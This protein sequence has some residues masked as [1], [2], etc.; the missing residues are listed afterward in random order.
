MWKI[1]YLHTSNDINVQFVSRPRL[2]NLAIIPSACKSSTTANHSL[3]D[4]SFAV[5]GPKLWNAMPY[6]LNSISEQE[7][8]KSQLTKFMLS[9]PDTPPIRGYTPQNSNLTKL[10]IGDIGR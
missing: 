10:N 7:L 3:Y 9:L 8:F 4:S 5:I 1:F 6:Y 2:G